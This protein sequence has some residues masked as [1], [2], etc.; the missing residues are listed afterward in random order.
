[1]L[2]WF[3]SALKQQQ[4][5][6]RNPDDGVKKP[7]NAILGELFI[8]DMQD[9]NVKG[10]TRLVSEQVSHHPPITA[11]CLWNDELGIR[12]EGYTRQ[13]ISFSGS[14]HIEQIGHAILHI[15]A[16]QEDYLVPLPN[17]T[18]TGILSGK[19]Y[20]ELKG[21]YHITSSSGYVNLVSRTDLNR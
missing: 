14:V 4:Y 15:D 10:T 17:V 2:K 11:C 6:G 7:L 8:V 3:L 16:F 12:A 18:V 20:P 19:P 5:A 13:K 9:Q 1:M 21:T